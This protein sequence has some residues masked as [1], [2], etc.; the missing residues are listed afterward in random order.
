M[1]V[2]ASVVNLSG[3]PNI[4]PVENIL[5]PELLIPISNLLSVITQVNLSTPVPQKI[6]DAESLR[7]FEIVLSTNMFKEYV[8]AQSSIDDAAFP[9]SS[10]V[11]LIRKAGRQLLLR[12]KGLLSWRNSVAGALELT[13]KLIDTVFGKLPGTIAEI[14]AK[15]GLSILEARRRVVIYDFSDCLWQMFHQRLKRVREMPASGIKR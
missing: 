4:A 3:T 12:N 2:G 13:P 5:A 14:S 11:S 9:V 1:S 8:H 6:V 7:R 15:L 10:S